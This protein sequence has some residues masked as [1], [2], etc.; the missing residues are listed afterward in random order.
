V[1]AGVRWILGEQRRKRGK[2]DA[3]KKEEGKDEEADEEE[4]IQYSCY[5][6]LSTINQ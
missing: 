5:C 2:G 3:S 1:E 4:I 6:I